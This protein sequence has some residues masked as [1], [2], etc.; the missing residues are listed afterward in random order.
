MG[1]LQLTYQPKKSS[2]LKVSWNRN[3][4]ENPSKGVEK[5]LYQGKELQQETEIYDFHARG[6][7]PV[8]GRT[9]QPDPMGE[10]FYDHSPYSWVKNNPLLRIDPTGMTDY[11]LNKETGEISEVT[12][13]NEEEQAANDAAETDRIVKTKKDGTIKRNRK[14]VVKSTSVRDIEKGILADGQNFKTETNIIEVGGEGQPSE[15]G[16]EAFALKLSGY[17]GVEIGGAYFSSEGSEGTSHITFGTYGNNSHTRNVGGHGHALGL[18]QGLN[19]TGFFHTHPG[20][21]HDISNSDRLVP[22]DTDLDSRDRAL[23][24]NPSLQFFLITA[25]VNYGDPYPK[26]IP[27]RT[28]YSR[29]LR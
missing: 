18:R 6:Y 11:T 12:Y 28:G 22:S 26:K 10:M 5:Y 2:P 24:H 9:W 17:V 1:C 8:L 23:Q 3:A 27:Y 21:G 25:P 7:D 20:N 4:V 13:D 14:G 15:Q 19:L 16:V 29:R